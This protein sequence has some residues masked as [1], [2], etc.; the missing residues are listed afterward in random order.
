MESN[1]IINYKNEKINFSWCPWCAYAKHEFN[2]PCGMIYE[3][4]NFTL[5]Q[6]RELPI[7]GFLIIS[8]K[9]HVETLNELSVKEINEMFWIVNNVIKIMK[10]NNICDEFNVIF[11]EKKKVHFHVRIMPRH[12][13]M[14]KICNSITKNIGLIFDYAKENFRNKD[15]YNK[16]EKTV[17]IIRDQLKI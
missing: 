1:R 12:K 9:K 11:E 7:V 2:L 4:D 16:I 5:S 13:W 14:M 3:N 15:T 8:P 6:D 10:E 17:N